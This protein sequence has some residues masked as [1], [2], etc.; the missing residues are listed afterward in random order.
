M[1]AHQ[2]KVHASRPSDESQRKISRWLADRPARRQQDHAG[3]NPLLPLRRLPQLLVAHRLR[4]DFLAP[5][6]TLL[7]TLDTQINSRGVLLLPTR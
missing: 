3:G 7:G 5:Q 6:T 4:Q 1:A 2:R